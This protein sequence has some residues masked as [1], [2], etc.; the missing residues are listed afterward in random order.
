M[1]NN[2]MSTVGARWSRNAQ[3]AR[4]LGISVMTLWRWKHDPKPNFP[5]AAVVNEIEHNDLNLIDAWMRSRFAAHREKE[6]A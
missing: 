3:T 2:A 1:A 4:Y 5:P 6:T